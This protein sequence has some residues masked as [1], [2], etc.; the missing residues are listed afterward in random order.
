MWYLAGPRHVDPMGDRQIALKR[1]GKVCTEKERTGDGGL[2]ILGV[3]KHISSTH[4]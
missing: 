2:T 3:V 1:E 4:G